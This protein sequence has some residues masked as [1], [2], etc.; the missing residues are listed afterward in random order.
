M[1][2]PLPSSPLH[3]GE[4]AERLI[5]VHRLPCFVE[6][7]LKASLRRFVAEESG[8]AKAQAADAALRAMK[9]GAM[10]EA[11]GG[12]MGLAD[13]WTKAYTREWRQ[14]AK[15]EEPTDSLL[16]SEVYRT[17]IHSAAMETLL[18]I[19]HR[20]AMNVTAR[21]NM[22]LSFLVATMRFY[23]RVYPLVR[24]WAR[25]SLNGLLGV[26]EISGAQLNSET[27]TSH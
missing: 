16:F 26:T 5:G 2:I 22:F 14:Y 11:T 20:W 10:P 13:A 19:E 6:D 8:R 24:P 4:F 12:V 15:A 17:V 1:A 23:K 21:G 25:L 3:V 7:E 9:E 27:K 18:H